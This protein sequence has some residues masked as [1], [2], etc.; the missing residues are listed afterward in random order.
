[1]ENMIAVRSK[2]LDMEFQAGVF[3][4]NEATI[5]THTALHNI[6]WNLPEDKRP[7]IEQKLLDLRGLPG[8]PPMFGV[9]VTINASDLSSPITMIGEMLCNE[10]QNSGQ[11]TQNSPLQI[12]L[13]RA[14]D[15]AFIA[16]L[17]LEIPGTEIQRFYSDAEITLDGAVPLSSRTVTPQ[18]TQAVI[19]PAPKAEAPAAKP[20][21]KG[22]P[23]L[24]APIPAPPVPQAKPVS[25]P[26]QQ[27]IPDDAVEDEEQPVPFPQ[28]TEPPTRIAPAV[29]MPPS[30]TGW[31]QAQQPQ[32]PVVNAP[33]N[34]GP[35]PQ[36]QY[37][38]QTSLPWLNGGQ[39]RTQPHQDQPV[40]SAAQPTGYPWMNNGI[41]QPPEAPRQNGQVQMT[42]PPM[43]NQPAAMQAPHG[44]QAIRVIGVGSIPG[45][46]KLTVHTDHGDCFYDRNT[47]T[48]SDGT[49][50][51]TDQMGDM[52][53]KSASDYVRS[54]LD[55]YS[56]FISAPTTVRYRQ[57]LP[58]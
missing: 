56:G 34:N 58:A 39:T 37:S 52:L 18:T 46:S 19:P 43:P 35:Q 38:G 17:R 15:K 28:E 23:E 9:S 3:Q 45:D 21:V 7:R 40:P 55:D 10:W 24:T 36:V 6:F 27:D 57:G 44:V 53:Y 32:P 16:Y 14:F 22:M 31:Q 2:R 48:W 25:V 8:I 1:M 26:V 11:I 47:R 4:K 42:A 50:K 13:N 30:Q 49:L 41:A 12:C 5:V 20:N 29:T 51:G 33:W 54:P